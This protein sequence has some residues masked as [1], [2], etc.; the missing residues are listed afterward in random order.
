MKTNFIICGIC[1]TCTLHASVANVHT[2]LESWCCL[3]P[4]CLSGQRVCNCVPTL[5]IWYMVY[6]LCNYGLAPH[7][8]MIYLYV[9]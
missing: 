5:G 3:S 7:G 1:E 6:G 4:T 9:D 8:Y 2:V